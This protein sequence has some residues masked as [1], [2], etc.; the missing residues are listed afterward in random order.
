MSKNI[1]ATTLRLNLDNPADRAAWE[2]L[3]RLDRV[4]YRSVSR[5]VVAAVNAFFDRQERLA[6]DPYLETREKE[7]AFLLEIR[8][9]IRSSLQGVMHM[10]FAP[11]MHLMQ[12]AV[13][14]DTAVKA[15]DSADMDA[16]LDRKYCTTKSRL[17][18][19]TVGSKQ[20]TFT[21]MKGDFSHEH[22]DR[23][24]EEALAG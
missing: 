6:S 9:T 16:T 14:A 7:D 2:H 24:R 20:P 12:G 18:D 22:Y 5:A 1:Y 23:K 13:P 3:Q 4:Q 15:E 19:T 10:N 8:E 17:F 11:W 21:I